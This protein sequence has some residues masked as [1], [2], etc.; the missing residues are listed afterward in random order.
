MRTVLV[1]LGMNAAMSIYFLYRSQD[2]L[3]ATHFHIYFAAFLVALA[4]YLK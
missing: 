3:H 4:V 2:K 1:V